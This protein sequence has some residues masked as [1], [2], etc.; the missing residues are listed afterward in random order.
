MGAP[1]PHRSHLP[2]TFLLP[3]CPQGRA[4][5]G[6]HLLLP[7]AA[8]LQGPARLLAPAHLT[9]PQN[10]P[11]ASPVWGVPVRLF[12]PNTAQGDAWV[13]LGVMVGVVLKGMLGVMVRMV[14]KVMLVVMLGSKAPCSPA[15]PCLLHRTTRP[16]EGRR[17][18]ARWQARLLQFDFQL[19]HKPGRA[20]AAPDALSLIPWKGTF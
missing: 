5:P 11:R 9:P 16:S 18:G 10:T 14:L 1:G 2:G 6:I 19:N 3:P 17:R 12:Q 15:L 4:D 20:S 7:G 13:M 8:S